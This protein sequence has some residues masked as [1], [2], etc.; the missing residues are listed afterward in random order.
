M[1]PFDEPIPL[2]PEPPADEFLTRT[3]QLEP[4]PHRAKITWASEIKA[5]PVLWAWV[6]GGHGRIPAGSLSVA[7]GREGTGKSSWALWVAAQLTR[8]TLPGAF[9]G[10]PRRVF[11]VAVEDSWAHTLVPRLMAAGADLSM[12]GR[13][14]VVTTKDEEVTLSLPAD[15]GLLETAVLE[16][17]AAGVFIDPLIS[18]LGAGIDTH[19][20]RDTR[21]ALDPLA[22]LADKTGAIVCGIAHFGKGNNTDAASLIT[23]SGAFKN[24]P[25]TVF[26]FARDDTEDGGRVMTQVKNSLGRDDLP[27][28]TYLIEAVDVPVQDSTTSVGRFSFTGTSERSIHDILRDTR[29]AAVDE[30]DQTARTGAE[31]WLMDFLGSEGGQVPKRDVLKAA[32]GEFSERTLQR[33]MKGAMFTIESKGFPRTTTWCLAVAPGTAATPWESQKAG[34]TGATGRDLRKQDGATE[35][36]LQSR[37]SRQ[38]TESPRAGVADPASTTPV[39]CPICS[40]GTGWALV[41]STA[42]P[43]CRR[44]APGIRAGTKCV[45]CGYPRDVVADGRCNPCHGRVLPTPGGAA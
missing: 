3:P 42:G 10:Q 34:A 40:Q 30:E 24:V 39:E 26:G 13:F 4:A 7:A 5:E 20:E 35:S 21:S 1:N 29:S 15:I 12:V 6:E 45:D 19:K 18:V 32:R 43:A 9:W 41:A 17:R 8:G 2:P 27:S 11:Y 37:Q 31:H 36:E 28:L 23:G 38:A 22:K 33:A 16:H 14:E 25:R 44:C